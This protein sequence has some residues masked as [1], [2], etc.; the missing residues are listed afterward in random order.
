MVCLTPV[1]RNNDL[2]LS[3]ENEYHSNGPIKTRLRGAMLL[4]IALPI[5]VLFFYKVIMC[6]L[7]KETAAYFLSLTS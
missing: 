7:G 3:T 5:K 2:K 1:W 6:M 4:V